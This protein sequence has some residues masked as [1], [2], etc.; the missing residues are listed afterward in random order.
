MPLSVDELGLFLE[1]LS[2]SSRYLLAISGGADSLALTHLFAR[3]KALKGFQLA[4]CYVD[5]GLHP[6]AEQWGKYCEEFCRALNVQFTQIQVALELISGESLEAKARDIR[7]RALAGQMPQGGTLVTAHHLNDQA[8]TF[9]IQLLRG[10]G[11]KG[12]AAMPEIKQFGNGFHVRPLLSVSRQAIEQYCIEHEIKWLED[13]S[14]LDEKFDRNYIRHQLM[15]IIV[16]RW[17]SAS[18]TIARSS[19]HMAEISVLL[20]EYGSDKL[21][22]YLSE[23]GQKFELHD[24]KELSRAQLKHLLRLWLQRLELS[25]PSSR[26]MEI[27]LT[28]LVYAGEQAQPRVA[29]PGVEIRRYRQALYATKPFHMPPETWCQTWDLHQPL[30]LPA[31]LGILNAHYGGAGISL[32]KQQ[33]RR[34]KVRFYQGGERL[35]MRGG[36]H[37]RLKKW[38][39]QQAMP[40]WERRRVPLLVL[41]EEIIHIVGTNYFQQ[42]YLT[43]SDGWQIVWQPIREQKATHLA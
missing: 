4:A 11:P 8:E 39:Q 41:D 15:P 24:I 30:N 22:H 16:Q 14:N 20:D 23:D 10:A 37:Q 6:D 17:P 36:F 33:H 21:R 32:N 42:Q 5:H 3:L 18:H 25:L 28:E 7:Y 35:L 2:P 12:L 27:L 43:E 34:L 29:W 9:L 13:P 19:T 1:R 38:F 26:Q 31:D 40:P